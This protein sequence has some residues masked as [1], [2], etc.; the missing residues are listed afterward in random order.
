MAALQTF[1]HFEPPKMGGGR[2]GHEVDGNNASSVPAIV[3][4]SF[5]KGTQV[6]SSTVLKMSTHAL[7]LIDT[8]TL[9]I[10]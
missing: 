10:L 1:T 9:P 2:T 7:D 8:P 4:V 5:G 3:D 6:R